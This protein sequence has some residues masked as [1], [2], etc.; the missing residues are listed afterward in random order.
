[1]TPQDLS[2][3]ILSEIEKD[4]VMAVV[5]DEIT[6]NA[7][8]KYI[9]A[10]VYR[11]GVIEKGKDFQG[12][13]NWALQF[14]W[15]STESGGMPRSDEELGQQLRALTQAT[16]LVESGFKE[17]SELKKVEVLEETKENPAE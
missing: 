4:K 12:N 10:V 17:L 13:V 7:F 14:A 8:K 6:F 5:E 16:K 1:M 3:Q 11:H 2:N 15:S 9:L